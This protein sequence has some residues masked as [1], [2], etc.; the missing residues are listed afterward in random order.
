MQ[1]V[2][3]LT[4]HFCSK[5]NELECFEHNHTCVIMDGW[6][7]GRKEGRKKKKVERERGKKE[8]TKRSRLP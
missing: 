4:A 8:E 7:E 2:S 5:E 1:F 6:K 3:R